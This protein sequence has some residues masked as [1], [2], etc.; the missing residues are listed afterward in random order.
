MSS[1]APNLKQTTEEN[2]ADQDLLREIQLKQDAGQTIGPDFNDLCKREREAYQ[3]CMNDKK[4]NSFLNCDDY[5][6]NHKKCEQYWKEVQ[7]YR[8]RY[9]DKTGFEYPKDTEYE[10]W[11]SKMHEWYITGKLS[12][13]EDI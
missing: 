1:K 9:L 5:Y 8:V 10:K 7:D 4:R 13:P 3:R 6:K 11:R 2:K 12:P